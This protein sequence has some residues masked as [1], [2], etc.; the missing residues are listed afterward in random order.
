MNVG[1]QTGAL[2]SPDHEEGELGADREREEQEAQ[3]TIS[4]LFELPEYGNKGASAELRGHLGKGAVI[5]AS[6]PQNGVRA[7]DYFPFHFLTSNSK[8]KMKWI[9]PS[10]FAG[11]EGTSQLSQLGGPQKQGKEQG[12]EG[13]HSGEATPDVSVSSEEESEQAFKEDEGMN[14]NKTK[15]NKQSS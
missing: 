6:L 13:D 5:H 2:Q 15:P 11:K 4:K 9:F 1:I 3:V 14:H 7:M 8:L 10:W 12:A